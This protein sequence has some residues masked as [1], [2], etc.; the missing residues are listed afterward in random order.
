MTFLAAFENA[1]AGAGAVIFFII[2]LVAL[3]LTIAWIVFPFIVISKFNELLKVAKK[4]ANDLDDA[5]KQLKTVADN[6][7]SCHSALNESNRALQW[8][9]DHKSN[10]K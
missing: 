2:G 6:L 4:L 7:R 5:R 9:V 10:E 3:V 1:G 8:I